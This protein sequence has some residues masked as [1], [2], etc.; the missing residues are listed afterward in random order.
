[1]LKEWKIEVEHD[2]SGEIVKTLEY[3][4]QNLQEKGYQ[5][6]IRNMNLGEYTAHLVDPSS[7]LD[8]DRT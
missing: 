7:P 1:M 6:L 3:S 2:K 8:G 4:S 5:G